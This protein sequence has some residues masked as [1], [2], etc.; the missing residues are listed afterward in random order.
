ML[1][2]GVA[3]DCKLTMIAIGKVSVNAWKRSF[4]ISKGALTSF[5]PFVCLEGK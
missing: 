1:F 3:S 5:L 2:S 4:L